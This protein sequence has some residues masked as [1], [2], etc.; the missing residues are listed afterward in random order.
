MPS[1][2]NL[3]I[4][5]LL[6]PL[7]LAGKYS[8]SYVDQLNWSNIANSQC[9][10]SM[11]SPINIISSDL[12][13]LY[14]RQPFELSKIDTVTGFGTKPKQLMS[15]GHALQLNYDIDQPILLEPGEGD[16]PS[17]VGYQ[18]PQIHI[19]AANGNGSEH[20]IDGNK[21]FGELHIVCFSRKY[22][23]LELAVNNGIKTGD[24]ASLAVLAFFINIV[25]PSSNNNLNS[26]GSNPKIQE[27]S[28]FRQLNNMR[29]KD[30]YSLG[31]GQ[32]K[33]LDTDI[34]SH[35]VF[36]NGGYE[37]ELKQ[38]RGNKFYRYDGSF[39]TP[40]CTEP[41]TWTVF[42][43]PINITFAQATEY[44]YKLSISMPRRR[45]VIYNNRF[46]QDLNGRIVYQTSGAASTRKNRRRILSIQIAVL[47][48]CQIF[49]LFEFT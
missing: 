25:Q 18:C 29:Q 44:M 10:G 34:K 9:G 26:P 7:I 36:C 1:H 46:P 2:Y 6:W 4:F 41:V 21:Y 30:W 22:K 5:S 31:R 27:N 20:L 47:I 28:L 12:K 39:T 3:K 32:I 35:A 42:Q 33:I 11:Q 24:T 40:P 8:W 23:T 38:I 19:H 17:D 13:P 14:L 16:L 43:D 15:N 48:F 49:S 37:I 45:E